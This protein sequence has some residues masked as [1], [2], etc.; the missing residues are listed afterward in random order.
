MNN[1]DFQPILDLIRHRFGATGGQF[2]SLH[3]PA[4]AGNEK[5]YLDE[6]IDTTFVSSVGAFVD[7]FER[8]I[9]S[10]TGAKRAVV[11]VSGTNV[12]HMADTI[13]NLPSSV[14]L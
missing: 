7:R 14:V 8:E 4:F 3:A 12:L 13:V 5:R 11:C 10:F 2:V 9:A 1:P 6:C